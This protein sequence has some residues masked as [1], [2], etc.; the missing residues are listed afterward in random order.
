MYVR[1]I[2]P[3]NSDHLKQ[4]MANEDDTSACLDFFDT[5]RFNDMATGKQSWNNNESVQ[6]TES[7]TDPNGTEGQ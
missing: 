5:V 7:I 3:E 6:R 4:R 1:I 2:Y